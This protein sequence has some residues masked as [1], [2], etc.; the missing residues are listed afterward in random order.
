MTQP[1]EYFNG[2]RSPPHG[3]NGASAER[4]KKTPSGL[5]KPGRGLINT[6]G[7]LRY[8]AVFSTDESACKPANK[9]PVNR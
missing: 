1:V 8:Y 2:V 7:S 6:I 3:K 9:P 4:N 5:A